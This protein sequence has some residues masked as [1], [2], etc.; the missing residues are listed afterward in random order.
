MSREGAEPAA[1]AAAP[2][3]GRAG[4]PRRTLE[5]IV[6]VL[7]VAALLVAAR[8]RDLGIDEAIWTY[9]ARVWV[10][11]GIPPY[12]GPIENKP[13]GVFYVFALSQV[14]TG[15]GHMV[16]RLV[17]IAA[18]LGCCLAVYGIGRRLG[19]RLAG[20][21]AALMCGLAMAS[22]AAFGREPAM[23]ES[24]MVGFTTLAV[25]LVVVAAR[26]APGQRRWAMLGAGLALGFGLAFKQVAGASALG[27][28]AL[29]WVLTPRAERRP[30]RW[31]GDVA[32]AV[33][34]ALLATAIS[35][36][37]LLLAGVSL[38]EYWQGAWLLLLDPG[39]GI[40]GLQLRV[41]R[42]W[43][44]LIH[45]VSTL[46]LLFVVFLLSRRRLVARGVAWGAIAVWC[47]FE[48]LG[49]SAS[50]YFFL[51]QFRQVVPALAVAAGIMASL[52]AHAL[53]RRLAPSAAV[54]AVAALIALPMVP[55]QPV[56]DVVQGRPPR[57]AYAPWVEA[58]AWVRD[59]T[60]PGDHI[61]PFVFGGIVQ[62]VS[63]RRSSS[64][65]FNH[66]FLRTPAAQAG[67]LRDLAR[68][69]PR[70]I[71]V[72][73]PLPDWLAGVLGEYRHVRQVAEIALYE[74]R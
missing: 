3:A 53:A 43:A 47:G 38:A 6:A 65:H 67:A 7:V 73:G 18:I 50:G 5:L 52:A 4:A 8:N 68:R 19:D 58:G 29:A 48:W 25:F 56:L 2:H 69:P 34:G 62:T 60:R 1:V 37:P 33:A 42:L 11:D 9:V 45:P 71:A 66:H 17:A 22:Q 55:Q 21:F 20:A 59:H 36:V 44:K 23:T 24:Y 39:S 40:S 74:R 26:R 49:V 57:P 63:E 72:E 10:Q 64:R 35:L 70:I 54:A 16:P 46:M 27:V 12:Q 30:G 31:A 14:L 41:L 51:H 15:P 32:L 61:F 13:P 28:A